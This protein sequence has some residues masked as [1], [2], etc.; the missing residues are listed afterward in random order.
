M[1]TRRRAGL[2]SDE[3]TNKRTDER[4]EHHP[5]TTLASTLPWQGRRVFSLTRSSFAGQQRTGAALWSGDISGTWDSLRRQV[6]ASL[7]TI[8]PTDLIP[9]LKKHIL[10]VGVGKGHVSIAQLST[11]FTADESGFL[12]GVHREL[13]HCRDT[14][15]Q[16]LTLRKLEMRVKQQTDSGKW[17]TESVDSS[18][19]FS[20]VAHPVG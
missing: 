10:R 19:G 9:A 15:V 4:T 17:E 14:I 8:V 20:H 5:L 12:E 11:L 6:A 2:C 7:K 13:E 16:E 3:R 1:L 18:S